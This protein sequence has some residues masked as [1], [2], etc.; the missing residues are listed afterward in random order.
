MNARMKVA[1]LA[2]AEEY[3]NFVENFIRVNRA[4]GKYHLNLDMPV[5]I[6]VTGNGQG[7]TTYLRLLADVMK[8][9]KILSFS[10]E[11]EVFEWRMLFSDREAVQRLVSRM[12]QAAGFYPYFSGVIGLDLQDLNRF[13]QLDK[14]LFELIHQNQNRVL[15][16]LQISEKQGKSFVEDLKEAMS[17]YAHVET[18]CLIAKEKDFCQ[19]VRDEFRE[20]GFYLGSGTGEFIP[21]F[22]EAAGKS[23]YRSLSSAINE[24]IWEKLSANSENIIRP[25]DLLSYRQKRKTRPAGGRT[26]KT[27]GFG[28]H[29]Q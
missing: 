26:Q 7:N 16:C 6:A 14:G 25:G 3:K 18:L 2:G 11:E 9:E 28:A 4:A 10:G 15:F 20:R 8:E 29:E 1:A 17:S 19:F 23:G 22:V 5:L 13:E 27:I 12:K 24:V 21:E